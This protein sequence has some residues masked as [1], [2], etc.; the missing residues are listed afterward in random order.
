MRYKSGADSDLQI[1][2][3]DGHPDPKMNGAG[4]VSK[5]FFW[6]IRASV[7]TKNSG[8]PSPGS[9]TSS[10]GEYQTALIQPPLG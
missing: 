10:G 1:R 5:Q 7:W 2:E 4:A 3:G 8:V 9:A 6:T